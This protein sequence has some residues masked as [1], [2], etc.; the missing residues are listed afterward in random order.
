MY[1]SYKCFDCLKYICEDC[2]PAHFKDNPVS[3]VWKRAAP[4]KVGYWLR[5]TTENN[6]VIHH[7]KRDSC[8]LILT[9]CYQQR[10]IKEIKGM[11]SGFLWIGPFP[12]PPKGPTYI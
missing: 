3:L 2:G 5:A 7:V 9:W 4:N 6:I 10:F 1:K 11:L 12:K 8:R